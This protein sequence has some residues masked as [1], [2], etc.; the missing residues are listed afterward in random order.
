MRGDVQNIK[1]RIDIVELV[2]GYIKLEKSGQ[3]YKARCPF[4]NER[5]ASFH[6]SP[7][8]QSYYCF[9]CGE[10]G[11]AFTFIEKMEGIDFRGALTL[12]A[13]KAGVK[14]EEH[15]AESSGERSRLFDVLEEAAKFYEAELA[16]HPEAS[17]YIK[18]RGVNEETLHKFH[19]GFVSNDW[20]LLRSQLLMQGFS[21]E[22]LMKVGLTK[23]SSESKGE[24][25]DVF[26]GRIIFPLSDPQ[27]RIIA[28]SGRAIEPDAV[29]KY[30]NSPD[31]ELF[32]KGEVLYGFDKAKEAI[33]KHNYAVLVEGQMDLVLSHQA[34]VTQTVASSGTAFTIEHLERLRRLSP[35]I[36]LAFDADEAGEKAAE[37]STILALPL[38][39][40]VKI[41]K[42]PPGKDP[43]DL[44][45][46]APE[47]WKE[48]LRQSEPAIEFFLNRVLES[49]SDPGKVGKLILKRILPLVALV[50]S[51]IE[52][53]H[54]IS[55][56]AK[57]SGLREAALWED[58]Q[59]LP[60]V[61]QNA[62]PLTTN[63]VEKPREPEIPRREKIESR[64]EEVRAWKQEMTDPDA[65][66]LIE[67]EEKELLDNLAYEELRGELGELLPKLARA[68]AMKDDG[69]VERLSRSIRTIHQK[70]K[71]LEETK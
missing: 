32:R 28:F 35:R 10:K 5:T 16:K 43:A 18:N 21:D 27:S 7:I 26:R 3:S 24:P 25:Y 30:L 22:E 65:L 33:R 58:L 19:I 45:R 48:V 9:G 55:L 67:K 52:R 46:E 64:L 62:R 50:P 42:L 14:L 54:Y 31:T 34:G 63:V 12:L 41:A 40:E 6:I 1:D 49:E 29:P 51:A 36:I 38:G 66:I 53:S 13:D 15:S 44:V 37:K 68:E 20:R 17:A 2:S 59:R 60:D 56:I 57:R 23:R 11:D 61:R 70:L 69:E 4:H 39:M 47:S 8:R 71:D